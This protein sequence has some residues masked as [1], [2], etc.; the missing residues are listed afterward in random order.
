VWDARV[1]HPHPAS[2]TFQHGES[3]EGGRRYRVR[4]TGEFVDTD[5]EIPF[6]LAPDCDVVI[7]DRVTHG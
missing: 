6:R 5:V 2:P 3:G 7:L 1:R 4:G